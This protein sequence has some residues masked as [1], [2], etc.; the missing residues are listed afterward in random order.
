MLPKWILLFLILFFIPINAESSLTKSHQTFGLM[1]KSYS[2]SSHEDITLYG[3][4]RRHMLGDHWYVG[5]FGYGAILG[6]RSGYLEGGVVCGA[7]YPLIKRLGMDTKVMIGAGG[8]GGAPQGGGL[9]VNPSLGLTF[10]LSKQWF[11]VGDLGYI[12][13]LN[14]N[15]ESVTI[16]LGL[17]AH[18]WKIGDD[19]AD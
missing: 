5:E 19:Y 10:D 3:A 16:G 6:K 18:F 14:G 15:I 7:L 13:F 4:I 9:I 2:I 1:L 8:G 17:H 11:V 12:R